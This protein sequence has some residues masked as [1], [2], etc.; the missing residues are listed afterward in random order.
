MTNVDWAEL[1]PRLRDHYACPSLHVDTRESW[2]ANKDSDYRLK[3]R[4]EL[5]QYCG[6]NLLD[7][8]GRPRSRRYS[9]SI[10]HCP[11]AGGFAVC[12][13][14][15]Q[16]GF[17][18]DVQTRF[19]EKIVSRVS[20]ANE[21]KEAPSPAHLWVAKEACFKSFSEGTQ[22]PVLSSITISSWESWAL[23]G[24]SERENETAVWGY[25]AS[26]PGVG[27]GPAQGIV[28][29]FSDLLLAF[30]AFPAQLKSSF[31]DK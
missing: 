17:D 7:L 8:S 19:S 13:S 10:S 29:S 16:I 4:Q 15:L 27:L 28:I 1:L 9:I 12:D 3:I 26:P 11:E 20:Q 24:G 22:P 30:F 2:R 21:V 31:S 18:I 14:S 6:E 25:R 5:S 23:G